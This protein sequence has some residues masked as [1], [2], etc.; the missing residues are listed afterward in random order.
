MSI[1]VLKKLLIFELAAHNLLTFLF[2]F[3]YKLVLSFNMNTIITAN[4][5]IIQFSAI[6]SKLKYSQDILIFQIATTISLTFF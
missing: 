2:N 6:I 3:N 5:I 4:S 1:F